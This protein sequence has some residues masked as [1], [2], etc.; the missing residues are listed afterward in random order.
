MILCRHCRTEPIRDRGGT[1]GQV[2]HYCVACSNPDARRI[3]KRARRM[4][5]DV[6]RRMARAALPAPKKV[7][8]STH[9]APCR[10]PSPTSRTEGPLIV[11]GL[12]SRELTPT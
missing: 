8:V 12:C 10:C 11:C 7:Y 3:R 5:R 4:D 9:A 2:P 6:E 1:R